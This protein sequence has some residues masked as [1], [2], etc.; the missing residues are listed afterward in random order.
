MDPLLIYLLLVGLAAT[1][2]VVALTLAP[3]ARRACPGC[4]D[5]VAVSARICRGCGY[6]FV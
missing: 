5:D 4:A 6:Q 1:I 2:C 3:T